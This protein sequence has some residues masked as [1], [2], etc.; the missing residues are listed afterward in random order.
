[1]RQAALPLNHFEAVT[2]WNVLEHFDDPLAEVQ[3]VNALLRD[4]GLFVFTTANIDSYLA[5]VQ[6]MK[7]RM[8]I[9]PIHITH[10]NPTSVEALLRKCGFRLVQN[11]VALPRER[12]LQKFGAIDL[13]KKLKFSDKFMIFA[14]KVSES[15]VP[16]YA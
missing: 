9:P 15:M 10:Y 3:H 5:K 1:M 7:W 13:F 2:M 12:L 16:S 4:G 8:F 14:Q 11:S 6:G